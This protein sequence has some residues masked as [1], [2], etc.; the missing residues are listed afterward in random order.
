MSEM[1]SGM[2][3]SG[4]ALSAEQQEQLVAAKLRANARQVFTELDLEP[5]RGGLYAGPDGALFEVYRGTVIS[6][7]GE[8]LVDR[9]QVD[10]FVLADVFAETPV[11]VRRTTSGPATL[12]ELEAE[13]DQ[14]R[15]ARRQAAE[16]EAKRIAKLPRSALS[17][18]ELENM[19]AAPTLRQ[20]AE[21]L[22]RA[23]GKVELV[24]GELVI[25][26]PAKS[27][28][29]ASVVGAA[30]ILLAGKPTVVKALEGKRKGL[31]SERLPDRQVRADG[32][33]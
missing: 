24:D 15:K 3:A 16:A 27:P 32:G 6:S 8:L 1:T 26:A 10:G 25:T 22:E 31:L 18:A 11:F 12:A 19:H 5:L 23:A 20:A 29:R 30:R 13:R 21:I 33:A 17:F 14:S 7:S 28:L 2:I 4:E 9:K